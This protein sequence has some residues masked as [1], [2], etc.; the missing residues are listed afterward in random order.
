LTQDITMWYL[1]QQARILPPE[2]RRWIPR[3]SE[4]RAGSF[5]TKDPEGDGPTSRDL[6]QGRAE[7][8][9]GMAQGSGSHRAAGAFLGLPPEGDPQIQ[10]LLEGPGLSLGEAEV[11][12]RMGIP[13]G[14]SLLVRQRNHLPRRN[15]GQ[16]DEENEGLPYLRGFSPF[17]KPAP[18]EEKDRPGGAERGSKEG[19]SREP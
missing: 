17:M 8:R 12:P 5:K 4:R 9:V 16:L 2:E 15:P 1:C 11:L 19:D 7:L 13:P 14:A 10:P 3:N 18:S 6:A